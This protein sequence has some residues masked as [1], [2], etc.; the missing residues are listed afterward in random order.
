MVPRFRWLA[1]AASRTVST[2]R[3]A[4]LHR[5]VEAGKSLGLKKVYS[6]G[7]PKALSMTRPVFEYLLAE[8]DEDIRFLEERLG[9]S[10]PHWRDPATYGLEG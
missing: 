2:L 5:V 7:D 9:R 4:G 8:H 6:G 1:L 10:F 3:E